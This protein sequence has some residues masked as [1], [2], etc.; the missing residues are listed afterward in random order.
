MYREFTLPEN[1]SACRRGATLLELL[2][3]VLIL[4]MITAMTIPVVAPAVSGRRIREGA[5]MVST[6]INAAR[7]RAIETGRPAGVWLERSAGLAEVCDN[8]YMADVPPV[9]AGDFLDSTVEFKL[10]DETGAPWNST[11]IPGQQDFWNIIIPRTRTMFMVDSWSAPD[12]SVQTLV[13][14]GDLIQFD[15]Y[16]RKY[17]LKIVSGIPVS[18][19]YF[20][21]STWW[22]FIRGRNA[23][24]PTSGY[25]SQTNQVGR[26]I[27]SW[28]DGDLKGI[29]WYNTMRT[30]PTPGNFDRAGL[31]YKIYRQPQRLMAGSIRLPRNVVIDLNYSSMTN[32]GT[33]SGVPFHP[34]HDPEDTS[35]NAFWGYPIY[36]DDDTPVIFTFSPGGHVEKVYRQSLQTGQHWAW[37]ADDPTGPI[38]LLVGERDH[39]TPDVY[40][41]S[42]IDDSINSGNLK[43]EFQ[44][45][46]LNLDALWIR[47]TPNGGTV[48]TSLVDDP[49]YFQTDKDAK[50]LAADPSNV[51]YTRLQKAMTGRSVGGR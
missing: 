49:K 51:R 38:Y 9:Y 35:F 44:K 23:S 16:D 18:S 24:S 39:I 50:T 5:R 36:P 6:F 46:W 42:Q 45:N 21:A 4:L 47:I 15:G 33:D 17:P 34:R 19:K 27:I 1:S 11:D 25:S 8:L 12:P 3:V 32:G 29:N 26:Y 30:S 31:R 48:N 2:A 37:E 22:Y 43:V 41:K 7:N 10:V 13:R 14:E 20:S 28:W 40:L